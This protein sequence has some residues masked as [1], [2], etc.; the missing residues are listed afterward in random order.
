MRGSRVAAG[1]WGVGEAGQWRACVRRMHQPRLSARLR[2][3]LG[4]WD[5]IW[6]VGLKSDGTEGATD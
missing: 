5:E 6:C 1:W 2:L 4:V 3:S